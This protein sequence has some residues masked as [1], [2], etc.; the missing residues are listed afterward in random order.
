MPKRLKLRELLALLKQHDRRFKIY[1]ER[2]KGSHL[3]VFHPDVS[4]EKKS[5]PLPNHGMNSDVR[6]GHISAIIR[7]FNL[8][9]RIFKS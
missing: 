8:P 7:R 6:P 2:G 3:Q 1:R 4:G 5:Y 9:R